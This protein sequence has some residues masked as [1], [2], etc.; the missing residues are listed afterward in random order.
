M[1]PDYKNLIVSN[2]KKQLAQHM[3]PLALVK[4]SPGKLRDEC[5][6]ICE[7]RFDSRDLKTLREFFG[8]VK[9]KEDC[10]RAIERLELDKF[11]PLINFLKGETE[12]PNERNIELLAWLIDFQHRPYELGRKYGS[13]EEG[14]KE[15]GDGKQETKE[16]G[17]MEERRRED[18]PLEHASA[19]LS[20]ASTAPL[21]PVGLVPRKK[22][23]LLKW[24]IPGVIAV[25]AVTGFSIMK[26]SDKPPA[27]QTFV[28]TT[29]PCMYWTSEQYKAVPCDARAGAST[30]IAMDTFQLRNFKRVTR[31]DTITLKSTGK[32]W[33][34]KRNKTL[35]IF[36]APGNHPE[37]LNKQLKPLSAYLIKKYILKNDK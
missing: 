32:L 20:L 16:K 29:T 37:E 4:P 19:A 28:N 27:V 9:T 13:M 21:E 2:Y 3:L 10:I 24:L 35:E 22:T 34:L 26:F 17:G 14:G 31:M 7:E 25:V 23:G 1:F 6:K 5:L 30:V 11:K 33:Y 18:R 8:V 36:T 12:D 15:A